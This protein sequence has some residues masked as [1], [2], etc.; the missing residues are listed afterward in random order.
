MTGVVFQS[1]ANNK[2]S[3]TDTN[4]KKPPKKNSFI[5]LNLG[6]IPKVQNFPKID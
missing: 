3:A 2:S 5:N 4:I 1:F 6:K